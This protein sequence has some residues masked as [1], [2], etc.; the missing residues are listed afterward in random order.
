LSDEHKKKI[1]ESRIKYLKE[2][3]DKVPYKLNHYSK[4]Y[5]YPEKYFEDIFNKYGL[6]YEKQLQISIYTLDFAIIDKGINIEIDGD[7]HYLDEV[8]IKSNKKRDIFLTENN[9]NVIRIRWSDYKKMKYVDKKDYIEN[10]VNYINGLNKNLPKIINNNNYCIDCGI[11]INKKSKRCNKC[12]Y[13]KRIKTKEKRK[14]E[15]RPNKEQLLLD[16]KEFGYC[17]TG[18]KYGVCDNTIRKWLK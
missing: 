3:P 11:K 16:I 13:I 17:G 18:R 12:E 2:N 4:G 5:S 8:V 7:Q 10:L 9:W 6:I 1:S 15:N 14:V